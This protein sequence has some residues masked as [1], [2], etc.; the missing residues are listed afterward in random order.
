MD[1][2]ICEQLSPIAAKTVEAIVAF[3]AK[4]PDNRIGS[5]VRRGRDR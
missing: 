5:A 3:R 1:L 4:G 2:P